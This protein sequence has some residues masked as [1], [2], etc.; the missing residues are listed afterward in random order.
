MAAILDLS[1]D[2]FHWKFVMIISFPIAMALTFCLRQLGI[3]ARLL[4][5]LTWNVCLLLSNLSNHS[6]RTT[7][8]FTVLCSVF[9]CFE[10]CL[11][12]HMIF[13]NFNPVSLWIFQ[14]CQLNYDVNFFDEGESSASGLFPKEAQ[15]NRVHA[16]RGK[17]TVYSRCL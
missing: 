10:E 13:N 5:M 15:P 4:E 12:L 14:H 1:R 11:V 3:E 2:S 17:W 6:F 16:M 8:V 9:E 7:F